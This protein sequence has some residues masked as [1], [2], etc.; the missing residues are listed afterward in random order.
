MFGEKLRKTEPTRGRQLLPI[1]GYG[2]ALVVG[3]EKEQRVRVLL[4]SRDESC[5]DITT[6]EKA[7]F[8]IA[9]DRDAR[10][11]GRTADT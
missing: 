9:L 11:G 2:P 10:H 4:R 7:F 3:N 1:G 6:K 8:E 5:T